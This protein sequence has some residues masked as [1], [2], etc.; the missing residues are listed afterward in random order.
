VAGFVGMMLIEN[1]VKHLWRG[2]MCGIEFV[3]Y[4]VE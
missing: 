2:V 3:V 1:S 4:E